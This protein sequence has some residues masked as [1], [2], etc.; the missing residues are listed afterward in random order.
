MEFGIIQLQSN[1][2]SLQDSD[3]HCK[4]LHN[5]IDDK[6]CSWVVEKCVININYPKLAKYLLELDLDEDTRNLV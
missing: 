5:N 1:H 2:T 4:I 3:V 6:A